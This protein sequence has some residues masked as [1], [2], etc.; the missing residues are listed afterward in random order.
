MT[1]NLIPIIGTCF[2]AICAVMSVVVF[3]TIK[4]ND[5]KHIQIA[6]EKIEKAVEFIKADTARMKTRI[7]KMEVRCQERHK[8]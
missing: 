2:S 1:S 5:I 7:T 8:R 6:V 3:I 4:F